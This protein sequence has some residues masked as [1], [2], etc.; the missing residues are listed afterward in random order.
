MNGNR[1][2]EKGGQRFDVL[3]QTEAGKTR[4]KCNKTER[5]ESG[6]IWT[7]YYVFCKKVDCLLCSKQAARRKCILKQTVGSGEYCSMTAVSTR[8]SHL[9]M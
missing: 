4:V 5:G 9:A 6:R 8:I 7:S 2:F 1:F 3:V